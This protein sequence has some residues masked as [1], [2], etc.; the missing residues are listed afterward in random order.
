MFKLLNKE[1]TL[2]L[3]VSDL[4]CGLNGAIYFVEMDKD[5]GLSYDGNTAGPSYGTGYCDA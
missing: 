4:P 5:G 2:T 1:F 3:D